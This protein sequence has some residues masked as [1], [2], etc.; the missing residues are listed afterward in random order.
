MSS[1]T[2]AGHCRGGREGRPSS[3]WAGLS[4]R[5]GY[6]RSDRCGVSES[7]RAQAGAPTRDET[8]DPSPAASNVTPVSNIRP[9]C[10]VLQHPIQ[11]QYD[12]QY[13]H[14]RHL[15]ERSIRAHA[16][17]RSRTVWSRSLGTA[18]SDTLVSFLSWS[19]PRNERPGGN[20]VSESARA[21]AGALQTASAGAGDSLFPRSPALL[22]PPS[23]P[24]RILPQASTTGGGGRA[25]GR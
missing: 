24:P 13:K 22:I 7:A 5:P 15:N 9:I 20:G 19:N 2:W 6:D 1:P 14:A 23:P 8:T 17:R 10:A 11:D 21:R 25:P 16:R 18:D 3:S 4:R 12:V